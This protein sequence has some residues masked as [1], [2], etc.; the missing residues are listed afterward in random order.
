MPIEGYEKD[1]QGGFTRTDA[2][3]PQIDFPLSRFI[4]YCYGNILGPAVPIQRPQNCVNRFL[5]RP[6]TC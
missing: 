3:D 5:I 4:Y 1:P 6:R 2:S